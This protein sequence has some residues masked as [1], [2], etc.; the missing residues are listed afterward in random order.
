M[1]AYLLL[2]TAVDL[3]GKGPTELTSA[4]L[5]RVHRLALRQHELQNRVLASAEA[6][7]VSVPTATVETALN[8]IRRRYV[9]E[10]EFI[11]DLRRNGLDLAQ[12][13]AALRRELEVEAVLDKVAS[14]APPVNDIDVQLYY[15]YHQKRFN[16]P[17]RRVARHILITVN[18]QLTDNTPQAARARIEAIAARLA[19]NPKRF[20]EQAMK[21]SECPSALSGGLLGT[22]TR[23]QLYPELDAALFSLKPM[24]SSSVLE[25]P[26]GYHLL[27]CDAIKAG[28]I[29]PLDE[30]RPH[31]QR[32]LGER[33]RRECQRAWLEC[34]QTEGPV[35]QGA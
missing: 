4:E 32:L 5:D 35:A 28:G 1:F 22:F 25:S 3:Y 29:L 16:R 19:K 21:H 26:L 11:A 17:E 24:Q 20:E 7:G 10:A 27:R 9:S 33:R 31:I 13:T 6:S 2:K 23:G 18:P 8:E 30:V 15:H 14:Q 34:L 12:Y